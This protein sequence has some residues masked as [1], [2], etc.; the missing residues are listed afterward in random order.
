MYQGGFGG[1]P[2]GYNEH[3]QLHSRQPQR[4][5]VV[6]F[7]NS[8]YDRAADQFLRSATDDEQIAASRTM[9]EVARTYMPLMPVYFRLENNYVQPWLMG[10]SP[11]VFTSYWKYLD[12][13][14]A[15]R[16]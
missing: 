3:A 15:K 6:Q 9:S 4:V 10:F 8:E 5:N 16:R 2:S 12:I 13:D 11:F 7:K 14:L 1:S